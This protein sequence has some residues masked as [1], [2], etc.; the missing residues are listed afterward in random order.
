MVYKQDPYIPTSDKFD[1]NLS[2]TDG[3]IDNLVS[4]GFN[5]VRLGV[6]WE[7]VERQPGVYDVAYLNKVNELINRLGAKGIY[8]MVDAHQDVFARRI[9]G[10][11]VPDFYAEYDDLDHSCKGKI[12]PDILSIIGACKSMDDYD[13][14]Y[15]E[16]DDPVIEDC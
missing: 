12:V 11:G 8:T 16:N 5:L 10:E 3:D 2:L 7:A 9:C 14:R 13:L 15:D 4:W 6:M 1:P